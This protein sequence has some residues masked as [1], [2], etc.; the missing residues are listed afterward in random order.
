MKVKGMSSVT[1]ALR[2]FERDSERA[3][4]DMLQKIAG[5][6]LQSAL[7]R[8]PVKYGDLKASLGIEQTDGGWTFKIYASA[9][10]APWV[11]FGTGGF[12]VVEGGYEDYAMEFFVSGEG[13]SR[14][15]P[16]LFPP[17]IAE[18]ETIVDKVAKGLTE[19]VNRFNRAA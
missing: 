14:P 1:R 10:H 16:Y 5:E 3:A 13:H 11:E 12:V 6:I 18:R 15:Q 19:Y 9:K 4:K 2:A 8:V 7:L 17:F